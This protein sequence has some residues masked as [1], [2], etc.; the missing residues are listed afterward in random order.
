MVVDKRWIKNWCCSFVVFFLVFFFGNYVCFMGVFGGGDSLVD[1]VKL[2]V[3]FCCNGFNFV[4]I[5][6]LLDGN[7]FF[8]GIYLF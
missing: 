5:E 7:F 3:V 6:M 8:F 2:S 4:I 1:G